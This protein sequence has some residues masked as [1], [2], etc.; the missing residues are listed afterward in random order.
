MPED[1]PPISSGH[2]AESPPSED[3][4]RYTLYTAAD[5]LRPQLPLDWVIQNLFSAGSI[6]LLVGD[7][8]SGKTY[9]A[10][11]AAVCVVL[12]EPWL[13]LATQA[14]N[15][16]L[17]DE[18]NGPRRMALRVGACLRGHG[19]DDPATPLF[20]ISLA[21]FN[22]LTGEDA[23]LLRDAIIDT[24]ARFVVIDAL[25]DVMPGG[26]E[27]AAGDVHRVFMGL[28]TIAAETDAAILVI[29]HTNKAGGYRG[30]SAMFGAVDAL[31][32]LKKTDKYFKF[33]LT[34]S[35]DCEP[36]KFAAVGYWQMGAFNLVDVE[37]VP[38]V[39]RLPKSHTYVL[40]FLAENGPSTTPTIQAH[41]D[42]CS[43]N[44]ARLAVYKLT[45]KG[46]LERIDDGGRQ[47]TATYALTETGREAVGRL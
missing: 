34:A 39:V 4:P 38:E 24:D 12:G 33:N 11:D 18:E 25:V 10:L 15:V 23:D 32:T 26:D 40:R 3:A 43:A 22:L 1:P 35:H 2:V 7:P 36:F 47:S 28:R 27:N 30:S 6:S 8:K 46:L 17:V 45:D 9:A 14:G 41:A 5:A 37:L 44:T 19:I 21:R 42:T 29:H 31:L 13:S 16:L 20:Y